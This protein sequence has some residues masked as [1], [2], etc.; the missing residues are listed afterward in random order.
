[1]KINDF[2]G[3]IIAL[4]FV[5]SMFLYFILN[6]SYHKSI[7]AKY[8][9]VLGDYEN[10]YLY[11]NSAY[12]QENYNLMAYTIKQQSSISLGIL[13]YIN[14]AKEYFNKI[15]EISLQQYLSITDKK[16]M[17]VY[18]RI[19]VEGYDTLNYTALTD[20]DLLKEALKLR[21]EFDKLLQELSQ[22]DF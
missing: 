11:A 22:D 19:V 16:R 12:E 17:K 3:L 9:F 8:Y 14:Q 4:F 6:S 21:N 13:K 18:A 2:F 20:K 10:A 5:V 7:Q 15:N 1:M